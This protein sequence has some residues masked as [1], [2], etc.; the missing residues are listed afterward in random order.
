MDNY[1]EPQ[2]RIEAL[3]QNILGAS[4]DIGEPQSRNEVLLMAIAEGGGAIGN[5]ISNDE[6][7]EIIGGLE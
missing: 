5:P 1:G 2:S 3:L 7:D 4:Y 6:I